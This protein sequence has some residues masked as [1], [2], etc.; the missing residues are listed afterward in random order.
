MRFLLAWSLN[1]NEQDLVWV[2]GVAVTGVSM[3]AFVSSKPPDVDSTGCM[4]ALGCLTVF[5]SAQD[6]QSRK[7]MAFRSNYRIKCDHSLLSSVKYDLVSTR[8]VLFCCSS[9][10]LPVSPC[11]LCTE[12]LRCAPASGT[13]RSLASLLQRA[14]D[15]RSCDGVETHHSRASGST[16]ID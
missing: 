1:E 3:L 11:L 2:K 7:T 6:S 13:N 4:S 8:T 12:L 9:V 16:H 10:W 5:Q 14:P 15:C